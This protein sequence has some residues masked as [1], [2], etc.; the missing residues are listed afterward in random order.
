MTTS[1]RQGALAIERRAETLLFQTM[2][3]SAVAVF[4]GLIALFI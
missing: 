2:C 3:G 4:V 1:T